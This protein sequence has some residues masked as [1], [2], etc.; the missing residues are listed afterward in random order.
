MTNVRRG[1]LF[2][3][4]SVQSRVGPLDEKPSLVPTN[5]W[6]V[7]RS[8]KYPKEIAK[9]LYS[10]VNRV[11]E[12]FLRDVVPKA[13]ASSNGFADAN[14]VLVSSFGDSA[15]ISPL[16]SVMES[17]IMK[18]IQAKMIN[19]VRKEFQLDNVEAQLFLSSL[20]EVDNHDDRLKAL[21]LEMQSVSNLHG[22]EQRTPVQLQQLQE[23]PGTRRRSGVRSN[24]P[25]ARSRYS[26]GR[27]KN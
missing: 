13:L 2:R 19:F 11:R 9:D 8:K 22:V 24:E 10:R 21:L 6:H 5:E 3:K 17:F 14:E 4:P 25:N 27:K 15:S 1:M 7:A 20:K 26:R 18:A 23:V 16:Y 12:F